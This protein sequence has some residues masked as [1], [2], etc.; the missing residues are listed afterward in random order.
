MALRGLGIIVITA[1]LLAGC[2]TVEP[3]PEP[4]VEDDAPVTVVSEPEPEPAP[5]EEP[6][7]EAPAAEAIDIE[8]P[9]TPI[10]VPEDLYNQAFSEVEAVINELSDIIQRGDFNRWLTFLTPRYVDTYSHP[11]VL[12]RLSRQP[13][14]VQNNIRLRSLRDYFQDVVRPSRAGL[15]LDSLIFYSDTLVEAVT[16]F[17]GQSVT[18]YLLRKVNDEWKIDTFE[19]PPSDETEE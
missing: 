17:R 12:A 9:T 14:L 16:I 7:A 2:R 19:K 18:F 8:E 6:P 4:Q 15:R 5:V 10:T 1:L 13:L 11:E 3:I